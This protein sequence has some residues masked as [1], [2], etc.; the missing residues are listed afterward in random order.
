MF[1]LLN[2][3]RGLAYC[4]IRLSEM[5]VFPKELKLLISSLATLSS[6]FLAVKL[7]ILPEMFVL[8]WF[9]NVISARLWWNAYSSFTLENRKLEAT[10]DKGK[11]KIERV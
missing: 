10:V 7:L 2:A 9:T 3:A 4:S 8:C 6:T 5:P 11:A 1:D